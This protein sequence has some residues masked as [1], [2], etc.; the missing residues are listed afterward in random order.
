MPLNHKLFL[1]N[2][3]HL[4]NMLPTFRLTAAGSEEDLLTIADI[5][6]STVGSSLEP[7]S[8]SPTLCKP[9]SLTDSPLDLAPGL[10]PLSDSRTNLRHLTKNRAGLPQ[11]RLPSRFRGD[12]EKRGNEVKKLKKS[13]SN[14]NQV[15]DLFHAD[16]KPVAV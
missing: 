4:T 7:D 11:R 12:N 3:A 13:E 16:D 2:R 9:F 15:K 6:N 1:V 14:S 8:A 10:K 5:D